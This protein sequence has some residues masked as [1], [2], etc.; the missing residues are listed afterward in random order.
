MSETS[1]QID[2]DSDENDDEVVRMTSCNHLPILDEIEQNSSVDGMMILF[3]APCRFCGLTV[4]LTIDLERE[5]WYP[6]IEIE[7]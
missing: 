4:G 7:N 6:S 5:D 2:I 3:D 1:E